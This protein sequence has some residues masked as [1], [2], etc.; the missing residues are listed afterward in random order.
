MKRVKI[1]LT[2]ITVFAVVGGAL[3][4]KAKKFGIDYCTKD[5]SGK[6][7][8]FILNS[9]QEIGGTQFF[10]V[11]TT[12]TTNCTIATL[13]PDCDTQIPLKVQ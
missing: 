11:Q 3:A 4:F 9:K 8:S 2:A 1:M 6:C 5:S 7:T 13:A 12:N 10:A